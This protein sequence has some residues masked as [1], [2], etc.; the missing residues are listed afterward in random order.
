ML[1]LSSLAREWNGNEHCLLE[2]AGLNGNQTTV[3]IVC[4]ANT[5]EASGL[6][7]KRVKASTSGS[8]QL[9]D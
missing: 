4:F 1:K 7:V 6:S 3:Y 2:V 9:F 8:I 5:T